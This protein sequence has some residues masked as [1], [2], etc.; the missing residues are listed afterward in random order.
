MPRIADGDTLAWATLDLRRPNFHPAMKNVVP[1]RKALG[2]RTVFNILGPL[3]NPAAAGRALIGVYCEEM[4]SLMAHALYELGAEM[5]LVV[6]CGGAPPLPSLPP[7]SPPPLTPPSP[8]PLTPP[9]PPY[10]LRPSS[11]RARQAWT[12]SPRSQSRLSPPSHQRV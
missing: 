7:P 3:L 12:S 6:H 9:S 10:S 8:P 5:T 4:V 11:A 1:V 2:V